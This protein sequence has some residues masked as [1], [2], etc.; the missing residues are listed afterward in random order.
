MV[1]DGK[2]IIAFVFCIGVN[3]DP[4]P[5]APPVQI[6]AAQEVQSVPCGVTSIQ[7]YQSFV[8]CGQLF[9]I[10]HFVAVELQII[11][12]NAPGAGLLLHILGQLR[13]QLPNQAAD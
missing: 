1:Q 13:Q 5:A 10:E 4:H 12:R 9:F 6:P 3:D 7:F 2:V 8:Q 11:H